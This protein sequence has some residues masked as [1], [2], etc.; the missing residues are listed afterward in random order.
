MIVRSRK[1]RSFAWVLALAALIGSLGSCGA[2]PGAAVPAA[3]GEEAAGMEDAGSANPWAEL[4]DFS[5]HRTVRTGLPT[6]T[7]CWSTSTAA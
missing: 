7:R 3:S 1:L 2:V 5:E 4:T 6:W